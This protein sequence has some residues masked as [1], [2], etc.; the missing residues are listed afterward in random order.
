MNKI[1]LFLIFLNLFSSFYTLILIISSLIAISSRSWFLSWMFLE[2]NL[3]VFIPLIIWKSGNKSSRVAIKYFLIQS[4]SSIFLITRFLIFY[5]FSMTSSS[6]FNIILIVSL[7]LKSGIPP[8][9]LWVPSIMENIENYSLF[10]ILTWQKIAPFNLLI[11]CLN[12]FLLVLIIF[13]GLIGSLGGLNTNYFLKILAYSSII[14]GGWLILRLILREKIWLLYFLVYSFILGSILTALNFLKLNLLSDFI[15]SSKRLR[16]KL[17]IVFIL[18]S[19]GGLP[20]FLGFFPKA[21]VVINLISNLI[22][23]PS[24]L[25]V[26]FSFVSLLYYIKIAFII[27]L[28]QTVRAKT[29]FYLVQNSS[30][31]FLVAISLLL[32][33]IIPFIFL[34]F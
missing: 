11:N 21:L 24:Y 20:P 15:N 19:L 28:N 29:N 25:I 13:S 4:F 18:L 9:H 33:I 30:Y 6:I 8:F 5:T 7:S 1:I 14:H 23:F 12:E 16:Y 10:L 2:I 34:F 31:F 32:M 27:L 3:I 22:I 17:I 26:I